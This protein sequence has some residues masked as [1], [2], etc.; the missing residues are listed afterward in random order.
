MYSSDKLLSYSFVLSVVVIFLYISSLFKIYNKIFEE[1]NHIVKSHKKSR[2]CFF[3]FL[4]VLI[5]N[6]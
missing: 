3:H 2:E 1:T 4:L 5:L 6:I